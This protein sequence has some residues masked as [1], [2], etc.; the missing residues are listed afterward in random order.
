MEEKKKRLLVIDDE[1]DMCENL[2]SFLGRRG[3]DVTVAT[4][5]VKAVEI[6]GKETFPV[7]L[8][9]LK[10][11]YFDGWKV[12]ETVKPNHPDTKFIVITGFLE[13]PRGAFPGTEEELRQMGAYDFILKPI[14]MREIYEILEKL[15]VE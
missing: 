8:L 9:D 4:T 5:G 6:L 10:M 3:Y 11:P 13:P 14:K 7:V 15:Y 2:Q 12:L 1:E